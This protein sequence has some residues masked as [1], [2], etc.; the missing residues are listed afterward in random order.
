MQNSIRFGAFWPLA[1]GRRGEG[2]QG[3]VQG[4]W[5]PD[6]ARI[7]SISGIKTS[8]YRLL[9]SS[10]TFSSSTSLSLHYYLH[11]EITCSLNLQ[12][13][14]DYISLVIYSFIMRLFSTLL[15][16]YLHDVIDSFEISFFVY[17]KRV[18]PWLLK[19]IILS[20]H[21]FLSNGFHFFQFK[22]LRYIYNKDRLN[23]LGFL[24]SLFLYLR[25]F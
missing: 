4:G 18:W 3:Q 20:I 10:M 21:S 9:L 15:F 12:A 2:D 14:W 11:L 25:P 8:I 19:F 1:F 7:S 17:Y 6:Y 22:L 5:Q 13:S 24:L 16:V 23:N